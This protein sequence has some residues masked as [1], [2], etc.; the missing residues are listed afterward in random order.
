MHTIIL[1]GILRSFNI[2]MCAVKLQEEG[3][4][5]VTFPKYLIKNSIFIEHLIVAGVLFWGGVVSLN[6]HWK[7]LAYSVDFC[8]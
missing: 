7:V 8:S 1:T 3:F 4:N 6:P 2:L 5:T